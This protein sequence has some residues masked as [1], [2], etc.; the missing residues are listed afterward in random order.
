MGRYQLRLS[1]LMLAVAVAA[2][3]FVNVRAVVDFFRSR[4]DS[5]YAYTGTKP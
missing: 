5:P 3:I 2:A 4:P 1:T